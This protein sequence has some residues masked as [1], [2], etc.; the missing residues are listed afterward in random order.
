MA[1]FDSSCCCVDIGFHSITFAGMHRLHW[2]FAEGYII[3]KYR[4]FDNL[5]SSAKVLPTYGPF[6]T[7]EGSSISS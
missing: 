2:K 6:S 1:L 7:F 5:L 3:I 4:L